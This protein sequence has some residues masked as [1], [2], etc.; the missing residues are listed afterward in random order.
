MT[1]IVRNIIHH[2]LFMQGPWLALKKLV[3]SFCT[4]LFGD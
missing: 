2:H 1:N 3:A 4:E